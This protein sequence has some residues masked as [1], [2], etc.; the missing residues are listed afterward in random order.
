LDHNIDKLDEEIQH[1]G[2]K[3]SGI[4]FISFQA[5]SMKYEVL[6][7]NPHTFHDRME[8]YFK[9]INVT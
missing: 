4:A 7:N 1:D 5:E 3:F 2:T 9:P 6:E 8:A